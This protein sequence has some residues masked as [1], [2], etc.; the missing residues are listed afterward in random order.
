MTLW[1][2]TIGVL[3]VQLVGPAGLAWASARPRTTAAVVA[4]VVATV[5]TAAVRR[6]RSGAWVCLVLATATGIAGW[7]DVRAAEAPSSPTDVASVVRDG[8]FGPTEID[9]V[10]AAIPEPRETGAWISVEVTSV[11]GA[12]QVERGRVRLF[13]RGEAP[14]LAVGDRIR[15]RSRLRGIT[16]FGNPGEF[17]WAGWNARRG[18]YVA[19][20]VWDGREGVRVLAP[21]AREPW[22]VRIRRAVGAA[23]AGHESDAGRA[24][25]AALV[26]GERGYLS[27]ESRAWIRDAGLAHLLAISGLHMGLVVVVLFTAAHRGLLHSRWG[28]GGMD[29]QRAG[30]IAAVLGLAAY[31]AISGGGVSVSRSVLM[32]A[33]TLWAVW[34]GRSGRTEQA[35]AWAAL[36]LT[37]V[38]PGAVREASFQLSFLA[39]AV[40][41]LYG[42]RRAGVRCESA[43]HVRW[44]REASTVAV[45]AWAAT[46]PIAAQHFHRVS[47]VAPAASVAAALPAAASVLCGLVGAATVA[48]DGRLAEVLFAAAGLPASLLLAMA[49]EFAALPGAGMVVVAPG[50]PL[51][52]LLA[53]VPFAALL[54]H[55]RRSCTLAL[56][57]IGGLA[58][59]SIELWARY[60]SD[61]L[62][63]TFVSVG[64]GDSTIVRLPGGR[65]L[66]VDAGPPG[67]GRLIVTPLL[68]RL[69][70]S[71]L[72]YVVVTHVQSDHSGGVAE[73]A[74]ELSIGEFF[75]P[76]GSC[77][78]QAFERLLGDL[79]GRGVA[80][81]DVGTSLEARGAIVREGPTG[82]RL[83]VLWPRGRRGSCGDNDRSVVI[84]VA[85]GGR[86]VL[87]LGDLEAA[88][89]RRLIAEVDADHLHADVLKVPHHGSSTSSTEALLAVAAPR[90][91][92]ASAGLA[93]RYDFPH[94]AIVERYAQHGTR[95]LR[96]D[97]DGA[98]VVRV[99]ERGGLTAAASRR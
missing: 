64:Q 6:G 56:L 87:L 53:A 98:V 37:I 54:E 4:I 41:L 73:L 27:V 39:V 78:N 22:L 34:Q 28:R 77:E 43:A 66:L 83:E 25:V 90:L 59:G 32:A 38:S 57:A 96:T 69:R 12:A 86:T 71:H 33:A 10:V 31:A 30:A 24:L 2:A 46:Q 61:R 75:H 62:D 42:R 63:V 36:V 79:R 76:G 45:L 26:S 74:E 95:L 23:A 94:A 58:L 55:R 15:F 67:R 72:D 40:L 29:T 13:V 85:F 92:V 97:R 51:A 1:L 48:V 47:L 99:T 16:N 80:V 35:M 89:E 21:A 52:I 81:I 65:V 17:D 70:I 44:L 8:P 60:R 18:F 14:S 9:A 68:R 50:W 7:L 11:A 3:A 88:G 91:A 93:N 5:A 82:W 19:A 20:F 84:S 49:R